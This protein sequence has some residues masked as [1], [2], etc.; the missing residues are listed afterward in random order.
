MEACTIDIC[1][2]CQ[3][4]VGADHRC[5]NPRCGKSLDKG[6]WALSAVYGTEGLLPPET[7][8]GPWRLPEALAPLPDEGVIAEC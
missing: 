6:D 5:T 3:Y 2:I 4:P 7:P 8:T 1:P